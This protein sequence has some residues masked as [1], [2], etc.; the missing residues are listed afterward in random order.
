MQ[1]QYLEWNHHELDDWLEKEKEFED[2][3]FD[4]WTTNVPLVTKC[5]GLIVT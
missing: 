2:N 5:D 4:I 3:E 1:E